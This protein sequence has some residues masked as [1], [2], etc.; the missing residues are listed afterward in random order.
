MGIGHLAVGFAAKRAA[1]AVPLAI[2]LLAATLLDVLFSAFI[3]VG[4]EHA[5]IVPGITAASPLDFESYPYTH[6]LL[7]SLVLALGFALI[8]RRVRGGDLGTASWLGAT[9][10]SHWVLDWIT[11]RPDLQIVP[12]HPFRVGLGL[13]NHPLA[14][15]ITEGAMFAV[16]AWMYLVATRAKDWIGSISLFAF[17][18][19]LVILFALSSTGPPPPSVRALAV[20]GLLTWAFV[21][22]AYW[23]DRHR[24]PRPQP[25]M[26][27]A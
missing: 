22:W 20:V 27:H 1:P 7:M 8:W 3:L 26:A 25:V 19:V 12:W 23:I 24:E 16:G 4:V 18:A 13:W 6:S 17:W 9:V 11:H 2:L 5:R 14:T 21:P 10:F 15:M